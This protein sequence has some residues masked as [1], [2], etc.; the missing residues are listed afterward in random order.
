MFKLNLPTSSYLDLKQKFDHL[1]GSDNLDYKGDKNQNFE[2]EWE[3]KAKFIVEN[4]ALE[5]EIE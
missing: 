1:L 4:E 5:N 3:R 2:K